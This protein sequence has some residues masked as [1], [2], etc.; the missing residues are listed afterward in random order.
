MSTG[1]GAPFTGPRPLDDPNVETLTL[2]LEPILGSNS[3]VSNVHIVLYSLFN[4]FRR[5]FGG[6][7]LSSLQPSYDRFP[8]GFTSPVDACAWGLRRMLTP[9]SL[10]SKFMGMAGYAPTSFHDLVD[11]E[12]ES[13]GSS[14]GVVVATGHPLSRECAMADAIG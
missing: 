5:L 6:T 13:D 2:R 4:T 1:G 12:V 7:P 8:Y 3:T 14:L 10:T 9:P 11:D